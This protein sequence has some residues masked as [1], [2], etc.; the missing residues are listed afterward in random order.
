VAERGKRSFVTSLRQFIF[1]STT[2]WIFLTVHNYLVT[3][4]AMYLIPLHDGSS[5]IFLIFQ[6]KENE[7]G[8]DDSTSVYPV[9]VCEEELL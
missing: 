7:K 9:T 4:L 3:C 2:G 8:F 1:N 5:T 6:Q